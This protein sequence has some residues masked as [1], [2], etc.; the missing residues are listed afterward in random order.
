MAE[1]NLGD[2][3]FFG[4]DDIHQ[5][6]MPKHV[7]MR[8]TV[9]PPLDRH[10]PPY[11]PPEKVEEIAGWKELGIDWEEPVVD[12]P[13][14]ILHVDGKQIPGEVTISDLHFEHPKILPEKDP[15]FKYM[16]GD[17]PVSGR[18]SFGFIPLTDD[19][20]RESI[21]GFADYIKREKEEE[22]DDE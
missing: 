12:P 11:T 8:C 18:S 19:M 2:G 1:F 21:Q 15:D 14:G 10:C 17:L 20:I 3:L 9:G 16:S 5:C 7:N 4:S 13:K 6:G 22:D